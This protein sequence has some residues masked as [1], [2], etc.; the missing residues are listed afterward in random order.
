MAVAHSVPYSLVL[1]KISFIASEGLTS[2]L[3]TKPPS[4]LRRQ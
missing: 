4:F 3:R 2:F 1:R